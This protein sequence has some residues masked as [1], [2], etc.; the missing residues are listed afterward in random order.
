MF[1]TTFFGT[2]DASE[3][4]TRACVVCKFL[5]LIPRTP[6]PPDADD[7]A[8]VAATCPLLP[9]T[10]RGIPHVLA[11]ELGGGAAARFFAL[12]F[13]VVFFLLQSARVSYPRLLP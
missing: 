3:A 8:H 1:Q 2:Y 5:R 9:P 12:F 7:D 6:P 13:L 10:L 11:Q 4:S